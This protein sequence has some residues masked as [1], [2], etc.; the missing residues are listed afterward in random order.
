MK[1]WVLLAGCLGC[2]AAAAPPARACWQ[3]LDPWW[4]AQNAKLIVVGKVVKVEDAGFSRRFERWDR[5]YDVAVVEVRE[6]L[7]GT[8]VRAHVRVAQPAKGNVSVSTD[9][10]FKVG[11]EG[12]WLLDRARE[13]DTYEAAHPDKFRPLKDR[14]EV[15]GN[16]VRLTAKAL[17]LVLDPMN[18]KKV[19]REA[20]DEDEDDPAEDG[21]EKP[22]KGDR[23]L[24]E[25][26]AD[27]KQ[28]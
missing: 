9:I 2:L 8:D 18:Q 21:K 3:S 24:T 4:V 13:A 14:A 26:K 28:R 15:V 22:K 23:K 1:L 17:E 11:D 19:S 20:A 16:T 10:Q 7:K 27:P 5:R 25:K 12:I 6:V